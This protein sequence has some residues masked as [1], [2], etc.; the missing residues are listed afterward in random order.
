MFSKQQLISVAA[1]AVSVAAQDQIYSTATISAFLPAG[2]TANLWEVDCPATTMEVQ[3][4]NAPLDI[5][6]AAYNLNV[7]SVSW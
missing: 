7:E 2:I 6:S 4:S 5:C 1:L 3:C